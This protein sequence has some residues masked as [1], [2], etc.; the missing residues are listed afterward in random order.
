MKQ[1]A[2]GIIKIMLSGAWVTALMLG[3][4][5]SQGLCCMNRLKGEILLIYR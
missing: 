5:A 3:F 1:S 2:R 4:F